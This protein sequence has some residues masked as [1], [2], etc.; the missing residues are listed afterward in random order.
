MAIKL[1]ASVGITLPILTS[2]PVNPEDGTMYY[3]SSTNSMKVARGGEFS[4]VSLGL[5][6]ST[7]G[8]AAP[9][10]TAIMATGNN[11]SGMYWIKTTSMSQAVQ[12]Y[13]DLSFDSGGWMLLAYGYV[14]ST[15]DSSSNYAIPNLN[16]DGTAWSYNPTSRAST[17]G[18]VT[19]PNGQQTALLLAK[20][21]T[22][23]LFAAG[24]NPSSGGIDSYPYVYKF[25]IPN[26]SA[27]TFANHTY[28]Y[29]SSMTNSTVTVKGIKGDIGTWTRYTITEAIGA[30]WT[31]SYPT[32]YGAVDSSNPKSGNFDGGP[33]FP[34]IHS[35]SRNVAPGNP[36]V[37]SSSPDVGVNG[38][39]AGAQSYVYRGWYGIGIGVNQTGQTSIWVR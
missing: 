27:L 17:N 15:S 24:N 12:V 38:Y 36:T 31:D 19:T 28:Y 14:A 22:E 26:P 32:G 6:G 18:L 1:N 8:K 25:D 29:N 35:G 4:A 9:S 34:S 30:S 10:A 33:F 11:V 23:I 13:C 21:S 37:V 16:H 7:P 20:S 2:D 3:N 5:D 39:T